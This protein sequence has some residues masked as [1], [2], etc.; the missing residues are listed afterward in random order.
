MIGGEGTEFGKY[1]L[2]KRIALGGMGE[3]F[4][5]KLRGPVGFEKLLVIKRIL[6]HHGEND[7]F[8]DMFFAEARVAAQLNHA[9]VVQI[10]EMGEIEDSFFIAMEYIHGKSLRAI[11]DRARTIGEYIPPAHVITIIAK[12]C[13]GLSYAHNAKDIAGEA[14]SIIHRDINPQNLLISYTG[15]VKVIDFGIAKSEMSINNTETG[16]IKGKFVYMSPEQSAAEDLDKRSDIFAAGI[17]LHEAL[18]FVNPFLKA[19][20]VLSLDAIQRRDPPPVTQTNPKF[21]PFEPII[22][23]ALAKKREDRYADC[24]HMRDDLLRLLSNGAIQGSDQSLSEYMTYLFEKEI[25]EEKL[26]ILEASPDRPL[27]RRTSTSG[28]A[29]TNFPRTTPPSQR[30]LD[31]DSVAQLSY[32]EHSRTPFFLALA[33]ILLFTLLGSFTA[34][35]VARSTA[36]GVDLSTHEDAQPPPQTL[37]SDETLSGASTATNPKV[38]DADSIFAEGGN[39]EIISAP[40]GVVFFEDRQVDPT[41]IELKEVTG[42][43]IIGRGTDPKSDPFQVKIRYRRTG[44]SVI[45]AIDS[46]PAANLRVH[47]VTKKTPVSNIRGG[48]V[49]VVNLS[50]AKRDLRLDITLRYSRQ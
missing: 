27:R 11:L 48:P 38:D 50:H 32:K 22:K 33:G 26:T 2:L 31:P 35:K 9:N 39:L 4:L 10:Y 41:A 8:I 36:V 49:T 25:E 37:P 12:L 7:D 24:A 21:A 45:Y 6:Q 18:T 16:T 28:R 1:Y 29:S 17:C 19:N 46:T 40:P 47:G 13:D 20:V 44:M 43:V 5:A 14:L 3:I 42:T 34:S 30:A 23:K 15:A